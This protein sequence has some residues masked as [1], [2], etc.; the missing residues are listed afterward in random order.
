MFIQLFNAMGCYYAVNLPW[1]FF[2]CIML[3]Y[4]SIGATFTLLPVATTNIY[5]LRVGPQVY[6][7]VLFGS[8]VASLLNVFTTEWLLPALPVETG[9]RDLYFLGALTTLAT[10]VILYLYKEELDVQR[11]ESKGLLK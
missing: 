11:M 1:L 7:Q 3:N 8:F 9:F 2:V 10:L 6:V 5:G 4:M